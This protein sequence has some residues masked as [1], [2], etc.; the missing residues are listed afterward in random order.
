MVLER[1]ELTDKPDYHAAAPEFLTSVI[2]ECDL[3]SIIDRFFEVLPTSDVLFGR[4]H[5]RVTKEKLNLL[6]FPSS[7]MTEA[8]AGA[9]KI[10]GC[11]TVNADS[12]GEPGHATGAPSAFQV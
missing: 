1:S 3:K 4:L 7:T 11:E 10:V 5:Q 8:G 6:R 12:R 9:K 2:C